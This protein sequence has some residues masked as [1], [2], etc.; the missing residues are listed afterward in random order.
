MF[1]AHRHF[2]SCLEHRNWKQAGSLIGQIIYWEVGLMSL[3]G[4][5]QQL[6]VIRGIACKTIFNILLFSLKL[7][8]PFHVYW[9]GTIQFGYKI[10]C[11]ESLCNCWKLKHFQLNTVSMLLSMLSLKTTL[12]RTSGWMFG[13]T[14]SVTLHS[15]RISPSI[16][17]PPSIMLFLFLAFS[18]I[19]Q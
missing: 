8:H 1:I 14:K 12:G 13:H 15:T 7:I 19:D 17:Y 11:Y 2:V 10:A 5:R 6:V 16:S 9:I 3:Q 4:R 18:V